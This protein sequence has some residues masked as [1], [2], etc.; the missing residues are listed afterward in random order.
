MQLIPNDKRKRAVAGTYSLCRDEP[1]GRF[2]LRMKL[3]RAALIV[4]LIAGCRGSSGGSPPP[5]AASTWANDNSPLGTNLTGVEYYNSEMVFQDLFKQAGDWIPQ[6]L[7]G[8]VWNTGLPFAGFT[9]DGYPLLNASQAAGTL[10]CRGIAG[11]YPGGPYAAL[12]DG[13][14]TIEFRMDAGFVSS[15]ANSA[16]FTVTPTTQG[17][18]LK[19]VAS[20]AADPIRNIRVVPAMYAATYGAEPFTPQFVDRWKKFKVIR[21]M[22]WQKTND[23]TQVDWADVA[24][25]AWF[26]QATRHGVAPAY[27]VRFAN[28]IHADPW[29]CIP[30]LATDAYVTEFATFLRDNVDPTLK[31]HV[32][33]S[34]E[35]WNGIFAQA[36][37]A[38]Q[39]GLALGLSTNAFEAQMR[40]HSR[41]AV[42]IFAI[43][44]GVFGGTSR[45]V[46]V[47]SAQAANPWTGTTVMDWQNAYAQADALA[48]APYVGGH[49]GNP[50]EEAT[51]QAMT[52]QQLLDAVNADIPGLMNI[53]AQHVASTASRGLDLVCYESGQHLA[54]VG[55]VQN[56]TTIVNLFIAANLDPGM[57]TVY[58]N[59]LA[60]WRA[61]GG[62]LMVQFTSIR[63]HSQ[64][65]SFGVLQY[66]DE[67]TSPKLD[68]LNGFIDANPRWW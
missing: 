4:A 59:Y 53:V 18:H 32:E 67:T 57:K 35:V 64:Y 47:L 52:V 8:A 56:N 46:R 3:L 63:P 34:N 29:F 65:G 49:F 25:P 21:F 33:H 5:A 7:T 9:A 38:Q 15:S 51:T 61:A 44:S 50:S 31:I 11:R 54:P 16:A 26:S 22:D 6:D 12:W 42:E 39:Q 17:I 19:I 13:T 43:F 36:A 10:M 45:L 62:R 28:A 23:S 20:S 24:S 27:M 1:P 30:H 66:D 58:D 55:V 41:R 60:Q 40:Y 2:F 14:G 68:A 37:Y 48:I